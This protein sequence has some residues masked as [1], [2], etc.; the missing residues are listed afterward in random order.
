MQRI[1]RK[2]RGSGQSK[3]RVAFLRKKGWIALFLGLPLFL[4]S[5]GEETPKPT[6]VPMPQL[7][8]K[9]PAPGKKPSPPVAELKVEPPS[10]TMYT[11]NPKGKIDP[12]RPLIAEKTESPMKKTAQKAVEETGATPLERMDIGKLKLVAIIWDI[13]VPRAMVEDA[14]GNGYILV[15]GTAIGRNHGRVTEITPGTVTIT[16]RSEAYM[17]KIRTREVSLKLHAE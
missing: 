11:Y 16:E 1:K 13:Q 17:E 7:A 4:W 15:K 9:A 6:K 8:E 14:A 5:C 3:N 12:F 2:K 10:L